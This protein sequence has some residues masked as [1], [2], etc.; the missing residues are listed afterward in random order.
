MMRPEE[1]IPGNFY[2]QIFYYPENDEV[3]NIQTWIFDKQIRER[4]GEDR[5]IFR[6]PIGSQASE[7][8][9]EEIELDES[10][11]LQI[12]DLQGLQNALA[13]MEDFY[14]SLDLSKLA[15]INRTDYYELE[16]KVDE[17]LA[18]ETE[19][20]LIITIRYTNKG[21]SLLKRKNKIEVH[22]HIHSK[23]DPE[24]EK[25]TRTFFQ[26]RNLTPQQDYMARRPRT[27]LLTYSLPV[28]DSAVVEIVVNTF[29]EI[30]EMKN[31]DEFRFSSLKLNDKRKKSLKE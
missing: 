24:T 15:Q 27:R 28:E 30:Y 31:S 9:I 14:S 17:F 10:Q 2:F 23:I 4:K 16:K 8:D 20:T 7:E 25:R 11:L 21:I 26:N 29:K 18:T 19:D 1:L 5:W 12:M 13:E 22:F 3:P 6:N